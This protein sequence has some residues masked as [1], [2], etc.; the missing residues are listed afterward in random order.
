MLILILETVTS[1]KV[2][3]VTV[4]FMFLLLVYIL[5]YGNI[6]ENDDNDDLRN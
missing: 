4:L 5:L 2:L 3:E 6:E 1:G